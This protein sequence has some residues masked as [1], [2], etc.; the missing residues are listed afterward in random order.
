[1]SKYSFI[2]IE[3]IDATSEISS[4]A[5]INNKRQFSNMIWQRYQGST[6]VASQII[7]PIEA[8]ELLKEYS[9]CQGKFSEINQ[10]INAA[11]NGKEKNV[12]A[13]IQA[14]SSFNAIFNTMER[15]YQ[16]Y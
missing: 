14:L 4:I 8:T 7:D 10:Q 15:W 11:V 1:M 6:R 9:D 3:D 16:K 2:S 5:Q 13:A 12:S